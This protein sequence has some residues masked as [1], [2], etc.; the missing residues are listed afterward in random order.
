MAK[1]LIG[2]NRDTQHPWMQPV[3]VRALVV[4][5]CAIWTGVESYNSQPF[6]AMLAAGATGYAVWM[7]FITW[8]GSTKVGQDEADGDSAGAEEAG[9]DDADKDG[10]EADGKNA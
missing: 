2:G 9:H 5:V 10:N 6:W 3:W 4:F 7:Y 8:P 1:R